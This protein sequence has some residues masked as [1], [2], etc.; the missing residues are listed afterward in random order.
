MK[1]L[2]IVCAIS[3]LLGCGGNDDAI[4]R[5]VVLPDTHYTTKYPEVFY[6]QTDWIEQQADSIDFVLHVGDITDSNLPYQW[7]V[8]YGALRSLENKVPFTLALGNHDI[9][10][11]GYAQNRMTI[12]FNEWFPYEK[13]QKINRIGGTFEPGK[14]DNAYHTFEAGR[15]KWMVVTLEFGPRDEVLAWASDVVTAHPDHLVIVNTHA[16]LYSDSTR[17]TPERGHHWTPQ[18]Y[19]IGQDTTTTVNDGEH[20]WKK[21]VSRHANIRFVFSGHVLNGGLGTLISKG[22]NGNLVYQMLA[23]YQTGVTGS[24]YGGNG[25]LRIVTMDSRNRTVDVKTYSPFVDEFEDTPD[26]SFRF[27]NVDF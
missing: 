17:I 1:T 24:E 15:R 6:A 5:L 27:E 16:Y 19:G 23:N 11:N 20:I 7:G 8:A 18:S 21:F 9:G 26:N 14:L 13:Y 25:Y 12:P 2:A 4:V 3:L 22:E 10:E